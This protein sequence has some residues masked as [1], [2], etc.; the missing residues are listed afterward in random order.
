MPAKIVDVENPRPVRRPHDDC[1][2][3]GDRVRK[4]LE[5]INE[6][7]TLDEIVDR[8][9]DVW[10]RD[11]L[12]LVAV[13]AVDDA[14]LA[15]KHDASAEP[16]LMPADCVAPKDAALDGLDAREWKACRVRRVLIR[17]DGRVTA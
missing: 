13:E 3:A 10:R 15:D 6:P 16:R 4:Q 17:R 11:P 12:R 7:A 8:A 14:I 1:G 5:V 2:V 9:I